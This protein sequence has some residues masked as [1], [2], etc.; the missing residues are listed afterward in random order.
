MNSLVL[1]IIELFILSIA[2]I[3]P[4]DKILLVLYA[5]Y[6]FTIALRMATMYPSNE[7]PKF[8]KINSIVF[9]T[10]SLMDSFG[11]WIIFNNNLRM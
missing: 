9:K 5:G 11:S 10:T 2:N 1:E 7:H 3:P 4:L 6:E 8:S